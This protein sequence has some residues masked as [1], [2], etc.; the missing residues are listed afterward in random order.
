MVSL[1]TKRFPHR[2]ITDQQ[3]LREAVD[4]W[5]NAGEPGNGP[6]AQIFEQQAGQGYYE[7]A[8]ATGRL[9]KS[10]DDL[11][12]AVVELTKIRAENGDV[13]GAKAAVARFQGTSLG[14]R[15][16]TTI[17][18][19]QA[20]KGDL[21]GALATCSVMQ[22]DD[23]VFTIIAGKQID[24][25]EF[26]GA[27]ATSERMNRTAANQLFYEVGEGLRLRHEQSRVKALAAGMRNAEYAADFRSNVRFTLWDS[28]PVR[29]IRATPCDIANIYAGQKKFALAD[30][31][32]AENR[33]TYVVYVAVRQYTA[34]PVGAERLLRS[35]TN[36]DYLTSGLYQF[37]IAAADNG[38]IAEGLRFLNDLASLDGANIG[39]NA[40][41][42]VAR[43]WTIR[44]GAQAVLP[45]ARSRPALEQK[46]SALIGIAEA[47]GHSRPSQ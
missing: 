33:C 21:N 9:F 28:I 15:A 12:W 25:G 6:D 44:D 19:V 40:I 29:M 18:D 22:C 45:W 46:T 27:L 38:N 30:S 13:Q 4:D 39:G 43:A 5:K 3:L 16:I 8:G 47:L 34:D 41:R 1:L 7:D 32:I 37:A 23:E 36:R 31:M 20:R 11:Q 2:R 17:A 26:D 24:A 35:T 14:E 10:S 42:A